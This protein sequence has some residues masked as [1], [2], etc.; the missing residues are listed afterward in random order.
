[1]ID[2][3]QMRGGLS[4]TLEAL[5]SQRHVIGALILRELQTR[6]GRDN[7]GYLWMLVEPLTLATAV[8]A[9]HFGNP[10]STHGNDIRIIPFTLTGYCTFMIFRSIVSRSE[11]TLESNKQLLF[12]RMVTIFDMLVARAV[13]EMLSTV[14]AFVFLMLLANLAGVADAPAR[15]LRL[16]AGI[17]LLTWFSFALSMAIATGVYFSK[18]T[19]KLVHPATYIAMPISGAFFILAWIPQPYRSW[20]GWSPMNQIFEMIHSGV[21]ESYDSPYFNP[22]YIIGW[23]M[24][25]TTA[26]LLLLRVLRRHV[27]LS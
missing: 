6:Y 27:H 1:M 2:A 13:L 4:R 3:F 15:P 17:V 7:I 22:I 10:G 24:A 19:A 14:G 25:L 8:A 9:L 26:G 12:H 18:A 23:C 16:M 20:L 5:D 21:F 11:A